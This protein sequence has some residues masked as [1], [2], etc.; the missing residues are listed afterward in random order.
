MSRV[1]REGERRRLLP[2]L[3]G[4]CCWWCMVSCRL[5]RRN[6]PR[7]CTI[8]L[9]DVL[10]FNRLVYTKSYRRVSARFNDIIRSTPAKLLPR[11]RLAM[12]EFNRV[13]SS[14][15]KWLPLSV[16]VWIIRFQSE[17]D[18]PTPAIDEETGYPQWDDKKKRIWHI[19][20]ARKGVTCCLEGLTEPA[21]SLAGQLNYEDMASSELVCIRIERFYISCGFI[22]MD[23][24]STEFIA[25]NQLTE[26]SALGLLHLLNHLTVPLV[27]LDGVCMFGTDGDGWRLNPR[28]LEALPPAGGRR[29]AGVP[30]SG[31]FL[32]CGTF[33]HYYILTA[34]RLAEVI[35]PS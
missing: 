20:C 19:Q 9:R 27:V 30:H 17:R 24:T 3:L 1:A 16:A 33:S 23:C 5:R 12:L 28:L 29:V 21:R 35:P 8:Y 11:Y 7:I 34:P 4:R 2:S 32:K 10:Q 15:T 14:Q 6:S 25:R 31:R 18:G 13:V 22:C 26:T